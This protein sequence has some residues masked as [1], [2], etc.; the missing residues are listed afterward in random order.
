MTSVAAVTDSVCAVRNLLCGMSP[1]QLDDAIGA[2]NRVSPLA[3]V[4]DRQRGHR[5]REIK[6]QLSCQIN[7]IFLFF[8]QSHEERAD[9]ETGVKLRLSSVFWFPSIFFFFLK[10]QLYGLGLNQHKYYFGTTSNIYHLKMPV[11]VFCENA[12]VRR[13]SSSDLMLPRF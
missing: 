1:Q 9:C 5:W 7:T 10:K 2:L 11:E 4:G 6:I 3:L 12:A 13:C 8:Q